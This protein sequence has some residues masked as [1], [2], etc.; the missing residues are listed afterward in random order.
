MIGRSEHYVA[1]NI[2]IGL[3]IVLTLLVLAIVY[4]IKRSQKINAAILD[5]L[6]EFPGISA[7]NV[8]AKLKDRK[9]I[10]GYGD[11]YVRLEKLHIRKKVTRWNVRGGS[12]RGNL[13]RTLYKVI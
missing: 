11:I 12:A 10:V 8:R 3:V 2:S 13:D 6:K 7:Q 4:S 9:I 5:V 1:I